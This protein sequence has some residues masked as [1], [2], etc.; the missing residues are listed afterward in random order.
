MKTKERI[1]EEKRIRQALDLIFKKQLKEVFFCYNRNSK[2]IL[3]TYMDFRPVHQL[4]EEVERSIGKEWIV[5]LKR[6]YSEKH[7]MQ[8]LLN[9]FKENKIGICYLKDGEIAYSTIRGYVYRIMEEVLVI[10][11]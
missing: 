11:P 7:I 6:E 3:I 5:T 2:A 1:Q 9:I 8:T 4:Q 10:Y